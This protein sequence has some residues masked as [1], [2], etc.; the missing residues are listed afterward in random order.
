MSRVGTQKAVPLDVIVL[1]N[2][3]QVVWLLIVPLDSDACRP[4]LTS[5]GIASASVSCSAIATVRTS[6]VGTLFAQKC[7]SRIA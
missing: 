5:S 2:K 4:P 3:S 6:W 1:R 7:K